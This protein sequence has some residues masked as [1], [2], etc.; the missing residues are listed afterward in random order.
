[1]QPVK[2]LGVSEIA[3]GGVFNNSSVDWQAEYYILYNEETAD[4]AFMN[5]ISNMPSGGEVQDLPDGGRF[6]EQT[7]D[8]QYGYLYCYG[9]SMLFILTDEKFESD[10]KAFVASLGL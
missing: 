1:M 5:N 7:A 4:N 9:K 3:V 2:P 10:A 8:G 6:Y